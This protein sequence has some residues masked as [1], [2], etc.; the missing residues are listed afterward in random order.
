MKYPRT[1]KRGAPQA[2]ARKLF[3]ILEEDDTDTIA[4][5]DIGDAFFIK[6]PERFLEEVLMKHFRHDKFPSFQRQL[7]LYGFRKITRGPYTGAYAHQYFRRGQPELLDMVLRK[8]QTPTKSPVVTNAPNSQSHHFNFDK[9]MSSLSQSDFLKAAA[10]NAALLN[11]NVFNDKA[12]PSLSPLSLGPYANQ[13]LSVNG[14]LTP[15][16]SVECMPSNISPLMPKENQNA[17]TNPFLS[18]NGLNLKLERSTFPI[19]HHPVPDLNPTLGA[20]FSLPLSSS[21]YMNALDRTSF[22][23]VPTP[24]NPLS[25]AAALNGVGL[26]ALHPD[27]L[28]ALLSGSQNSMPLS[29]DQVSSDTS[30]SIQTSV[31]TSRENVQRTSSEGLIQPF[32]TLPSPNLFGVSAVDSLLNKDPASLKYVDDPINSLPK[33]TKPEPPTTVPL[34]SSGSSDIA[35]FGS[36]GE[37]ESLL[38]EQK[39]KSEIGKKM[40]HETITRSSSKDWGT[41]IDNQF[42]S[43]QEGLSNI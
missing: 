24:Q 40:L 18:W 22:T 23:T 5:N 29:S 35:L 9:A 21:L 12:I 31:V 36:L 6:H 17:H 3:Q 27:Y 42:S 13:H 15:H 43:T 25:S 34:N 37:L 26:E 20:Q 4:W 2:F 14:K 16:E 7:N 10:G 39:R 33:A 38:S 30:A 28:K 1:G 41:L 32:P 11:H 8:S 19:A